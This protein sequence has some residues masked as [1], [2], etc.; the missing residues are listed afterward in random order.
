MKGA[1]ILCGIAVSLLGLTAVMTLLGGTG[2]SCAAFSPEEYDMTE[3]IPYQ[4][5][6]QVLVVTT[7][8]ASLGGFWATFAFIRGRKHAYR[9]TIAFLVVGLVLG[10]TQMATSLSLRG[11]AAPTNMRV[12]LTAFTLVVFLLL[13][14]PG[15][16]SKV[17]PAGTSDSN[18]SVAGLTLF[19]GVLLTL[20][21]PVWAGP[22]HMQNG[23][24]LVFVFQVPLLLGGSLMTL[25]GILLLL[26]PRLNP[27]TALVN[28]DAD[29]L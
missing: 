27:Q 13:R 22:T 16:W 7:T 4:W 25:I 20:T 17:N 23:S 19:L 18:G 8:A 28:I 5:L 14:L 12:Y 1:K 15:I 11:K 24:N 29:V 3:L 10:G 26:R 21:T 6:Y 2:T 9:D